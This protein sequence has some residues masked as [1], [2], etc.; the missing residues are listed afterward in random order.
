MKKRKKE[1]LLLIC[2]RADAPF[3]VAN[4]TFDRQC[5]QCA[6]R[7]M[8]APS[9]R[10]KLEH[11]PSMRVLCT[12]CFSKLSPGQT[13]MLPQSAEQILELR[14]LQPNTWRFRN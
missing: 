14:S 7:V 11:N 12:C 5:G 8:M 6:A 2:E 13:R 1:G 9:G 4:S 3:T 10:K